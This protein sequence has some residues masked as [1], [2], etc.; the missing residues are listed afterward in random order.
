MPNY[1]R[2]YI[3]G[4]SYFFTVNLLERN[5]SLLVDHISNLRTAIRNTKKNKPFEIDAWVILPDH[6]HSIWTLP[7]DDSDYSGRWREIKI[8]FSKSLPKAEPRKESRINRN[9]RGIWQHH[10]WEH[11]IRNEIDYQRHMDYIHYNP[12]KHGLVKDVNEWPHSTFHPLVAEGIY[13]EDWAGLDK[14]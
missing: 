2:N 13:P 6:M 8:A 14:P 11:T 12:V 4:G 5:K 3:T 7:E 10:F 1:R 9:E